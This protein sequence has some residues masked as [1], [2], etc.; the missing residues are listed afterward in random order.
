MLDQKNNT[1]AFFKAII[2]SYF[3]PLI[4]AGLPGYL[5]DKPDLMHASYSTIAL[6]SLFA[7]I[8]CFGLLQLFKKKQ[9]FLY[10]RLPMTFF[11]GSIM[12]LLSLMIIYLFYLDDSLLNIVSSSF[13][14]SAIVIFTNPLTKINHDKV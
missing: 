3:F 6:P 9:I 7:T 13:I 1:L 10:D 4:S 12:I 2:P 11:L 8:I 14:G 5:L